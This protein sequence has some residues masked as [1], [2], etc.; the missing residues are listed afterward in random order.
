L[1]SFSPI[2]WAFP[3]GTLAAVIR[4]V[5][6]ETIIPARFDGLFIG[7]S[8]LSI[9]WRLKPRNGRTLKRPEIRFLTSAAVKQLAYLPCGKAR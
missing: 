6:V 4:L 8:H 1:D 9:Y 7:F 3:K 5:A 2:H